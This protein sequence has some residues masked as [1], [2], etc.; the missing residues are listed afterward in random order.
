M[1]PYICKFSEMGH[2]FSICI[3]ITS[4]IVPINNKT[5]IFPEQMVKF[6]LF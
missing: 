5:L 3:I 1:D 2:R 6:Q 4:K